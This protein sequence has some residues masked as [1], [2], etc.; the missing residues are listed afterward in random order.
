MAITPKMKTKK[1]INNQ[2][3]ENHFKQHPIDHASYNWQSIKSYIK[4]ESYFTQG[5]PKH[6]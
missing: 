3:H 4:N 2:V 1:I 6:V 5:I